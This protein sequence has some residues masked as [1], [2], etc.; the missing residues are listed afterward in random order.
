MM[1]AAAD[2]PFTQIVTPCPVCLLEPVGSVPVTLSCHSKTVLP[3]PVEVVLLY[4]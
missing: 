3:V 4:K 1:S 2:P